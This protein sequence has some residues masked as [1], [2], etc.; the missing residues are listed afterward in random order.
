MSFYLLLESRKP[1]LLVTLLI[2]Q[3]VRIRQQDLIHAEFMEKTYDVWLSKSSFPAWH[4][5]CG[6]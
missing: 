6:A 1:L 5:T 2:R 4:S 3:L